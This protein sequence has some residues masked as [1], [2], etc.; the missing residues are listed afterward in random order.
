MNPLPTPWEGAVLA[1]AAFRFTRLGGWDEFPLALKVR[2]WVIGEEWVPTVAPQV[3]Y[4][5]QDQ[6]DEVAYVP[7][8]A[9]KADETGRV[10]AAELGFPGKQ[11]TSEVANVQPSYRRPVLAHLVHCPF[12]LGFWVSVATYAAWLVWPTGSFYA[13][14]PFALSGAVGVIS[15]NWDA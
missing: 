14:A 13:L 4:M 10:D 11:P 12:C 2:R 5:P 9:E 6:I 7:A 1:L 3:I 8:G 15:K